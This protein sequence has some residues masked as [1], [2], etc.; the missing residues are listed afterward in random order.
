M[1]PGDALR[2]GTT[3]VAVPAG[4]RPALAEEIA[5]RVASRLKEIETQSNRVDTQGHA[6]QLAF[7]YALK[8]QQ[9]AESH[10]QQSAE[11]VKAIAELNDALETMLNQPPP[12]PPT[13]NT[14]RFPRSA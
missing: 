8:M 6:I 12:T 2:I 3:P 10:D 7:E 13:G 5:A 1:K 4:V 14:T 11:V 9:L